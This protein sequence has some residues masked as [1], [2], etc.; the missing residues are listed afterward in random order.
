MTCSRLMLTVPLLA[1]AL[2]SSLARAQ[3]R[4]CGNSCNGGEQTAGT[5]GG[6][7]QTQASVSSQRGIGGP[8][9]TAQPVGRSTNIE[10]S[11]S[12]TYPVPLF[13]LPRRGLNLSLA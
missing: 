7:I 13:S 5:G 9:V 4:L 2:L 8:G 10:G 3:A 6:P 1:L 11:Q 12:Y